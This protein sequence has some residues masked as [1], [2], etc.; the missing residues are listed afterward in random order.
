MA[1]FY[2]EIG[3]GEQLE[4]PPGSGIWDDTITE[5]TY[6]GDVI[7]NTG[8]LSSGSTVNPTIIFTNSISVI[9]DQYAINNFF[10]ARY[11]RWAGVLWTVT[12]AEVRVPRLILA[13][14]G[15]YNGTTA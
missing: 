7:R 14:G 1:R 2:G 4:T 11:V 10:N 15:V 8:N 9:A 13:L 3:Y 12:A 6:Q 5:L